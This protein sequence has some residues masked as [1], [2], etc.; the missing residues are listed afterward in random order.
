MELKEPLQ[1]SEQVDRLAGHGMTGVDREAAENLLS[2]VSYYRFSGYALQFRKAPNDSDF[3]KDVCNYGKVCRI[4]MFDTKLRNLLREF[5]ETTEIY[6]RTQ[7][8]YHFSMARCKM[9][10][11][12]Q[13]YNRNN[14]YRKEFFDQVMENFRKQKDYYKDS[15]VTKHHHIKYRDKYPLWVM[16]EMLSF[17]NVSKLYSSMCDSDKERIASAVGT[18]KETLVNHLHCLSVLR[19]KCAHAARLYNTVYNPPVKLSTS[20]LK[21]N[22]QVN[23]SSLFA[24][25]LVLVKRLPEE[26]EKIDLINR[27]DELIQGYK[28]DINMQIIGFPDNYIDIL[29]DNRR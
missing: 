22:S 1:I 9:P 18:G 25:I 7:I 6:Y 13:H 10:P 19:N 11:H 23:N 14:Y 16:T 15:L 28:D 17:S 21:K 3:I 12:D 20:F 8:S 5:I 26:A 24:Y 29:I 4:Y 27:V 2:V